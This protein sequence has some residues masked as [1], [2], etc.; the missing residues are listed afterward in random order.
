[1][2]S[3]ECGV[4]CAECGKCG[5]WKMRSTSCTLI[6]RVFIILWYISCLLNN[7]ESPPLRLSAIRLWCS[8]FS[9]NISQHFTATCHYRRFRNH[10]G[11]AALI[12]WKTV[13]MF[14]WRF[15][16]DTQPIV[17]P[18]LVTHFAGI[19][20][21]QLMYTVQL[22]MIKSGLTATLSFHNSAKRND[23]YLLFIYSL[24]FFKATKKHRS[25]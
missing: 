23:F 1:M 24:V 22:L 11:L 4:R 16:I 12:E 13:T 21:S 7:F 2:R 9:Q 10:R 18:R 6:T 14:F 17:R 25:I 3:A 5:V 8:Q 19:L 15:Y 20:N